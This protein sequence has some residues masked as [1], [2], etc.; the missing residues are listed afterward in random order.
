MKSITSE[1]PVKAVEKV[2]LEQSVEAQ[3]FMGR[4]TPEN[5]RMSSK[6]F[7]TLFVNSYSH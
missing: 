3:K 7:F 6:N 1:S 2:E 4:N 5:T